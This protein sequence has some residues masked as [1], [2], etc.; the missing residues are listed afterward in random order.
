[1]LGSPSKKD[2]EE[3]KLAEEM[4]IRQKKDEEQMKKLLQENP[5]NWL[6]QYYEMM[7]AEEK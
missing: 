1:M 6:S 3:A 2:R 4:L 5:D 7:N